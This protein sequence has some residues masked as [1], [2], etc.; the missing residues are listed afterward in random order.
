MVIDALGESF[1][2]ALEQAMTLLSSLELGLHQ[3]E[4][5]TSR[6]D[7]LPFLSQRVS[8]AVPSSLQHMPRCSRC[9]TPAPDILTAR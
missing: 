1:T 6:E 5:L 7:R 8:N 2:L 3:S 9:L 4:G